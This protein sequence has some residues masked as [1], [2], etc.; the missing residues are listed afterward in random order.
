MS[1]D[2]FEYASG[3]CRS[4]ISLSCLD[5]NPSMEGKA[6]PTT[7]VRG[8]DGADFVVVSDPPGQTPERWPDLQIVR[9]GPSEVSDPE[10]LIPACEMFDLWFT[11]R[12]PVSVFILRVVWHHALRALSPHQPCARDTS[13]PMFDHGSNILLSGMSAVC[14]MFHT[15]RRGRLKMRHQTILCLA[16]SVPMLISN[17]ASAKDKIRSP[18]PARRSSPRRSP[19]WRSRSATSGRPCYSGARTRSERCRIWL[20]QQE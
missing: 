11:R 1:S 12:A 17:A 16:A 15:C 18:R 6:P 14:C 19:H 5:G 9:R 7:H 4:R 13:E 3:K 10:G 8:D 2:R 20:T